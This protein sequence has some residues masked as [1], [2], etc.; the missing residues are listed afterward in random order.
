MKKKT[1]SKGLSIILMV[2]FFS[3]FVL[4]VFAFQHN[5]NDSAL[6][7]SSQSEDQDSC[8]DTDEQKCY[9]FIEQFDSSS[10]LVSLR[11][12]NTKHFLLPD[13][14]FQAV[15]SGD[16]VHR[17]NADG[18]W[19]NIDNTLI[20]K[21]GRIETCD[22]RV[23]FS[24]DVQK[25]YTIFTLRENGTKISFVAKEAVCPDKPIV[26]NVE[27]GVSRES[28]FEK[29]FEEVRLDSGISFRN[30][31]KNAILEYQLHSNR[32]KENIILT[33]P[34]DQNSYEFIVELEGLYA[35]EEDGV[36]LFCDAVSDEIRY[37]VSKP[38]MYDAEEAFSDDVSYLLEKQEEGKYLLT[39][40][41]S[42]EWIKDTD[43]VFP[44]TIDPSLQYCGQIR[45]AYASSVYPTTCYGD[46]A[47]LWVSGV[48][49][50]YYSFATPHFPAGINITSATVQIPFYYDV[51][52]NNYLTI[53]IY[54]NI[55]YWY[56]HSITWNKKPTRNTT[57]LDSVDVYANGASESN[58]GMASF[59][60][61]SAVQSWITDGH[62]YGFTLL[63]KGGSNSSVKLIAKEKNDLTAKLYINYTGTHFAEGVYAVR[64]TGTNLYL[65]GSR[66]TTM[67][68]IV[69]Y[70]YSTAPTGISNLE[71]LFKI[72]YRPSTNDYVIRSMIDNAVI[73][74]P[75]LNYMTALSV[76]GPEKDSDVSS[77]WTWNIQYSSGN[78]YIK[79]TSNGTTYYL[80]SSSSGSG[81]SVSLV[82]NSGTSGT[83]WAFSQYSG[84]GFDSVQLGAP[85]DG[86]IVGEYHNFD[87]YVRSTRIGYN[88]PPIYYVTAPNGSSTTI[89]S[90]NTAGT[91]T[92][93]SVGDFVLKI[94]S[95]N[96]SGITKPT[97]YYSINVAPSYE[98][99]FFFRNV[100]GN[101]AGSFYMQVNN[102]SSYNTEGAFLEI[103]PFDGDFDQRWNIVHIGDQRYKIVLSA[104]GKA[105]TAPTS[106]EGKMTQAS[107]TG[108]DRQKWIIQ[109]TE[110]G[111]YKFSPVSNPTKFLAIG[112]GP[113]GA[114]FM[115]GRNVKLRSSQPNNRDEWQLFYCSPEYSHLMIG[116]SDGDQ[117]AE[118]IGKAVL[119]SYSYN[120]LIGN[121]YFSVRKSE[122]LY[123]LTH[124][125]SFA[126][127]THGLE[128]LIRLTDDETMTTSDLYGLSHNAL[129]NNVFVLYAACFCGAEP[130]DLIQTESL[131]E[132]TY[133][134]GAQ[135]VIGFT[136]EIDIDETNVWAK[137]FLLEMGGG[138]TIEGALGNADQEVEYC[139]SDT[140][141]H[142]TTSRCVL[143]N[144]QGVIYP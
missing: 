73:V 58:P 67:S 60:V 21:S 81:D 47:V 3:Q 44:I 9:T 107:Y 68:G 18:L 131:V 103:Q 32:I 14:S 125:E 115:A 113:D 11:D 95:H 108:I 64:K 29:A 134:K 128:T 12:E 17:K 117:K 25:D 38:F 136:I 133:A 69:Q 140:P 54:Q 53:G 45:D 33:S 8:I 75:A 49:E 5:P 141:T 120:G 88:G 104:S 137:T 109:T 96:Y 31:W 101:I 94:Q 82:T 74:R 112:D 97:F 40:V 116:A 127:L 35:I 126:C 51:V 46:A 1:F 119:T 92:A 59:S 62:N 142:S 129:G 123:S 15:V 84:T 111:Y 57:P 86:M 118:S 90:V 105:L 77:D 55:G 98:G 139:F 48:E 76:K 41:A 87:A 65:K 13:G 83:L 91:V 106:N 143:G 7:M 56:E 99:T 30:V 43:R 50:S 132:V 52:N 28:A 16:A 89:A 70:S 66:P 100:Q 63:R 2:I 85:T 26:Q 122:A 102:N 24:Q 72:S 124:S 20:E 37:S 6:S 36:I 42:S 23:S 4:S 22:G 80:C 110:E 34:T 71:N 135:C 19:V 79:H 121:T 10:E 27:Y 130:D 39:L 144:T 138:N 93:N 114:F 61:T 78:Y